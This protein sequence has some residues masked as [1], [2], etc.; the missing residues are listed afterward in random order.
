[1]VVSSINISFNNIYK[2]RDFQNISYRSNSSEETIRWIKAEETRT[3]MIKLNVKAKCGSPFEPV[4]EDFSPLETK[5]SGDG[6]SNLNGAI[7]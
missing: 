1:M 3:N 7:T 5:S 6:A 2:R 4:L